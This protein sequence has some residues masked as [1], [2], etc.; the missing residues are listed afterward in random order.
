MGHHVVM[1]L[2]ALKLRV[3]GPLSHFVEYVRLVSDIPGAEPYIRLPD[4][5][6]EL[7]MRPNSSALN[8]M[9]TRLTPLQKLSEASDEAIHVRFK[10]GGAYPFF[11]V[12]LSA[13]TDQVV[14]LSA[15]LGDQIASLLEA[16]EEPTPLARVAAVQRALTSRLR[17]PG[18]EPASVPAVR[19]ALRQIADARQLPSVEQLAN[20]LGASTR[21]LRRAFADVVGVSPKAYLR[22]ARFQRVLRAARAQPSEPWARLAEAHGYYDQAHLVAELRALSGKLPRSLR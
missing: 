15:L 11:G 3:E 22:I 13:L 19:R 16:L 7:V 8:V 14:P 17:A 20:E 2:R 12:P 1:A 21:Q 18:Y 6:V 10:A 4:G 9:G 5:R